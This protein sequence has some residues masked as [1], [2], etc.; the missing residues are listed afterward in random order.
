MNKIK[1]SEL[2]IMQH[3]TMSDWKERLREEGI[4]WGVCGFI[5]GCHENDELNAFIQAEL[6]KKAEEV[7][8]YI[9]ETQGWEETE[10]IYRKHF[11]FKQKYIKSEVENE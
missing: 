4:T 1:K 7:I 2:D 6:D 8:D 3:Q 5:E 10:D 9:A 11:G